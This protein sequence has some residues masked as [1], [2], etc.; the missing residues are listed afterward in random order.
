MLNEPYKG[1]RTDVVDVVT[2]LITTTDNYHK[3][4]SRRHART[5]EILLEQNPTGKLL[6]LGTT[7]LVPL[8]LRELLPEMAVTVTDFNLD[9]PKVDTAHVNLVDKEMSVDCFRINFEEEPIPAE[10][11]S[12]DVVLCSEVIEHMEVDPMRLMYEINR[13]LKPGGVLI[14]TT[15][16]VVSS[17]AITKVL[18]GLEPYFYMQYRKA[19][20]LY[21]HNYE[22]SVHS[23]AAVIQ[24]AGFEGN[25]WTEDTF[26]EPNMNDVKKV[27]TLGYTLD[28][29]GDNI[30]VVAKKVGPMVTRFPLAIY[31]D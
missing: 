11:S 17:W 31:A 2:S 19:G 26:E 4:H 20:E 5:I 29:I 24:G 25:I 6:E 8:A 23:I 16:N 3:V 14:L 22:Y 21:R 30:F 10:D 28:H 9:L 7:G 13:V 1:I 18:R 12:F 15:P 27:R